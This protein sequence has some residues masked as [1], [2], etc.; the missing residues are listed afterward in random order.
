M[1]IKDKERWER[2]A[3]L[4]AKSEIETPEGEAKMSAVIL[5][6]AEHLIKQHGKS[7]HFGLRCGNIGGP[8]HDERHV[9]SDSKAY[10]RGD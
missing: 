10:L 9:G 4:G 6:L 5:Q 2:L 7:D 3:A 8:P 1:P